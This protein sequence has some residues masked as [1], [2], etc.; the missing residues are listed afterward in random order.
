[1]VSRNMPRFARWAQVVGSGAFRGNDIGMVAS[2]RT[3]GAIG[4]ASRSHTHKS[5]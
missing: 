4:W 5:V 1:M 3:D 2:R